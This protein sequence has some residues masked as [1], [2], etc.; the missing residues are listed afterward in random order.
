MEQ[1]GWRRLIKGVFDRTCGTVGLVAC[2]PLLVGAAVAVRASMG[3]PVF[4]RQTRPGYHGKPFRIA[5]FRTMSDARALDGRLLPDDA[6]LTRVGRILRTTSID[7]LPQLWNVAKGDM[8]FVGPR[9]LIME[10]LSRYTPEEARRNDVMPGITGMPA[11]SGRLALSWEERFVLD[12][13]YVDHW[14]LS[15]DAKILAK[16]VWKVLLR[17]G[18]TRGDHAPMP[19]FRPTPPTC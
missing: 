18:T 10:Y 15:L 3:S 7:E 19:E 5:K 13:W 12:T 9:P 2:A 16:T 11:V 8:S 1:K 14:S 4:F 6:R 17:E